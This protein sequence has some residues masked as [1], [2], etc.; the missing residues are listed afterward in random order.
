VDANKVQAN[1]EAGV[2]TVTLPIAEQ[3]KARE[4]SVT[5]K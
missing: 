1:F 5:V 2:L 4:I 3:A